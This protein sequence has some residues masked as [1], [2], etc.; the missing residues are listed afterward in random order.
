MNGVKFNES[1]FGYKKSDVL[2]YIE[3]ISERIKKDRAQKEEE[4]GELKDKIEELNTEIAQM[5]KTIDAFELEKA[6]ISTAIVKAEYQAQKIIE[7]AVCEANDRKNK[8]SEELKQQKEEVILMRSSI[9]AA[10]EKYQTELDKI[11]VIDEN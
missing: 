11:K 6:H 2:Q 3:S 4:L 1:F 5:R 10:M 7:E 8:L 9:M